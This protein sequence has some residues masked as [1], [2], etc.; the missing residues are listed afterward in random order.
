M[1]VQ[2]EGVLLRGASPQALLSKARGASR[3]LKD[4][5]VSEGVLHVGAMRVALCRAGGNPALSSGSAANDVRSRHFDVD[6]SLSPCG[7]AAVSFPVAGT[8]RTVCP[9][10]PARSPRRACA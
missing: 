9:G 8:V 1:L 3:E 6:S 5:F 10:I 4:V 2:Y 7:A